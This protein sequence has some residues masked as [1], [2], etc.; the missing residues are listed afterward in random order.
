MEVVSKIFRSDY[1]RIDTDE[2]VDSSVTFLSGLSK[3]YFEVNLTLSV[4]NLSVLYKT[5][6][7][8]LCYAAEVDGLELLVA[9]ELSFT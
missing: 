2:T 9:R 7:I 1:C 6:T 3:I 4:T 8:T 5:L